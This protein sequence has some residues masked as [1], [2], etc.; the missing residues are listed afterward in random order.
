[1]AG[2][3]TVI[4]VNGVSLDQIDDAVMLTDLV[5]VCAILLF[6]R[7]EGPAKPYLTTKQNLCTFPRPCVV[8]VCVCVSVGLNFKDFSPG[9]EERD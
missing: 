3:R 2:K 6:M 5:S 8:C 7:D 1:M 9:E 4:K